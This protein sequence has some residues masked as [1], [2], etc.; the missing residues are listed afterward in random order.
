MYVRWLAFARDG[1]GE[2]FTKVFYTSV[3]LPD[4]VSKMNRRN[5]FAN[6]SV[7]NRIR[8]LTIQSTR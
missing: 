7:R 5:T 4:T 6:V 8:S 3:L 2:P 1:T